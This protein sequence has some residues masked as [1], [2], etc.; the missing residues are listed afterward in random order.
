MAQ[1]DSYENIVVTREGWRQTIT[2]NRPDR[3]NALTHRMMEEIG[4]AVRAVRADAGIRALVLRGAGGAFCAGGDLGAMA[5]MPPPPGPG[6]TD[7]LIAPYRYFGYV[8]AELNRLPQAVI[9]VVEGP[10][11]GGGFGMAC[12]ADV[13][14]T[15][16]DA[17]YG[18]PEPRVG[19]IPSQ[20]IPYVVRRIGEGAARRMAVMGITASGR[21]AVELGIA[22][23]CCADEADLQSRL[24]WVLGEVQRCEPQALATVKR[25]VLD[26]E[27]RSDTEIC[28]DAAESLI[29]LLRRPAAVAGIEAF[30]AKRRPAW[31]E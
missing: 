19:F 22:H 1:A 21:E 16:E 28:D 5:D 10:A 14:I 24:D 17:K 12:C 2:F 11:A 31:A 8:L 15:H 26:C 18:M 27:A 29:G 6:E 4:A 13:V 3:R 20:I 7:P 9:A 25:L 23:Y 30:M